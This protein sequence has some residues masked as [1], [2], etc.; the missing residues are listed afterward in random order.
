MSTYP[1]V[2]RHNQFNVGFRRSMSGSCVIRHFVMVESSCGQELMR[3]EEFRLVTVFVALAGYAG[4]YPSAKRGAWLHSESVQRDMRGIEGEQRRE[5]ELRSAGA[6]LSHELALL[7]AHA[8]RI[9][10]V[11]IDTGEQAA[12]GHAACDSRDLRG[13]HGEAR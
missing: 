3:R 5:R 8:R 2:G 12:V 11:G 13:D 10:D 1:D 9:S 6:T 4:C 7:D